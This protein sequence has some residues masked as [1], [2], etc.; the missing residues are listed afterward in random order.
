VLCTLS[1]QEN[2]GCHFYAKAVNAVRAMRESFVELFNSYDII[3]MP[4]IKYKPPLLP[5]AG[6][7]VT[8][9]QMLDRRTNR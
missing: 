2:Y 1:T 4:T 9:K 6:I 7:T 5:K 8:G 3:I